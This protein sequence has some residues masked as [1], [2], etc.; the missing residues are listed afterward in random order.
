MRACDCVRNI[1]PAA[2]RVCADRILGVVEKV[3]SCATRIDSN[4]TYKGADM[5]SRHVGQW[6][7]MMNHTERQHLDSEY[8]GRT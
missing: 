4:G 8:S 6:P 3:L 1:H 2:A 5:I 7:K